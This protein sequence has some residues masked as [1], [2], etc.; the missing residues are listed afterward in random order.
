M[1]N[2]ILAK[3][4]S[5]EITRNDLL[6]VMRSIPQN[7]VAQFNSEE[8]RKNLLNELIGRELFY[9]D[10]VKNNLEND[11]EFKKWLEET[12]HTLLQQ[13]SIQQFLNKVSISDDEI[14]AY[15]DKNKSAFMAE[16][17]VKAS[18]ILVKEEEKAKE[19]ADEIKAGKSFADAAKDHSDCP[20]K[21]NG[22]DLGLFG[23]GKMVP[24]F[25]K[26]AFAL[27]IGELSHIVK[28]QFGY[29]LIMVTDK[30]EAKQKSLE[31]V[32]EQVRQ[33]LVR[34]QQNVAYAA[35]VEKLKKEYPIEK[36]E[37]ALK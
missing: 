11:A 36:N 19:I 25:E 5:V 37:D 18:H 7:Q 31:E 30:V 15:Y 14:S 3:V 24:E 17:Q 27:E 8:G 9:L 12:K 4:G 23:K 10:G 29:H 2:N 28:T 26:V 21:A 16:E 13:Y 6:N 20:S 22:G 32:K 33:Y 35:E 34:Q 1:D